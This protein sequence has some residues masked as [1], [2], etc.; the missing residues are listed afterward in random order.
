MMVY[1]HASSVHFVKF[2]I[3]CAWYDAIYL[4]AVRIVLL[5]SPAMYMHIAIYQPPTFAAACFGEFAEIAE[6]SG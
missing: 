6:V 2:V 3:G 4:P 5:P 1:T